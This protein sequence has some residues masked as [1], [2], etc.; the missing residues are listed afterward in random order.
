MYE[1]NHSAEQWRQKDEQIAKFK[2]LAKI[3]SSDIFPPKNGQKINLN[4]TDEEIKEQ[5]NPNR[6]AVKSA[7]DN[8]LH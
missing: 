7:V 8:I 6:A 3:E 4:F 1:M 5:V 2:L